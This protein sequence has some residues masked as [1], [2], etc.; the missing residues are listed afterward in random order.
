M[1]IVSY[2]K[3]SDKGNQRVD[4]W[5]FPSQRVLI[6]KGEV[7]RSKVVEEGNLLEVAERVLNGEV[8]SNRVTGADYCTIHNIRQIYVD[9]LDEPVKHREYLNLI[10][11]AKIYATNEKSLQAG[12]EKLLK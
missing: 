5:Y 1:Q 2:T 11:T 10:S 4:Y 8:N 3:I 7:E 9:P 6:C 12:I